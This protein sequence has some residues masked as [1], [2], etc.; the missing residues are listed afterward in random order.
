MSTRTCI[1]IPHAGGADI[2]KACLKSLEA[3][4]DNARVLLVD[5]ASPDE[6]V[7]EAKQLFPWIEILTQQRNLGFA[8]GCN[9]GMQFALQ[10]PQ[11]EF[12]LLL[13]NDTTQEAGWLSHLEK[14]MDEYPKL[15]AAQPHLLSIPNPGYLD[16][17]GAAGGLMDCYAF[18]FAY[19]RL[20]DHIEKDAGQYKEPQLLAWASGTACMLRV[21]ALRE[22][23]LLDEAFFMHME[24][25]DLCW[26]LRLAAWDIASQPLSRVHHWSAYSLD[27]QSSRKVYLNHLNSLRM[28]FKN[29]ALPRL[30]WQL[31]LRIALDKLAMMS[32]FFSGR[33]SH[34]FA[35]LKALFVFYLDLPRLWRQRRQ[36]QALRKRDFAEI[37]ALHYPGSI[38]IK[39][40]LGG[41]RKVQDLKWNPPLLKETSRA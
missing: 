36:V 20:L 27:A 11:C 37:E 4:R 35:A 33:F 15:G 14:L 29:S 21:K 34:A 8:G 24:E 17:S 30:F 22:V 13:N 9:A 32:Y 39:T 3:T 28:F 31:S 2:L 23:G 26:R 7:C 18:P 41:C 25:I 40:R 19:G 38:A 6:S 5:N 10:D 12:I 16:Y 1:V